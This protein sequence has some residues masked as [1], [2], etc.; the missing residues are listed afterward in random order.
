MPPF[1]LLT[2]VAWGRGIDY[3]DPNHPKGYRSITVKGSEVLI[4]GN[5]DAPTGK[6]WSLVGKADG[7]SIL[8]DF[9]P[10]GGPKDLLGKFDG[11]GIV[12]PDG[13]RWPKK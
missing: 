5:D 7:D 3:S 11:S 4:E 8:I 13:N 6:A 2:L 12:F 1:S 10:K 9:S